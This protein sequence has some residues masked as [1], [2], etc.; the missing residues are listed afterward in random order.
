MK[1]FW[2]TPHVDRAFTGNADDDE[3]DVLVDFSG[4]LADQLLK[5]EREIEWVSELVRDNVREIVAQRATKRG[6]IMKTPDPLP[7]HRSKN[8]TPLDEVVDIIK[9]PTFD[10][11]SA[12]R[13]TEA[14]AVKIPENIS[15]LIREYISI[16]SAAYRKNP[17]HN[18]EHACHVTMCARFVFS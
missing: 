1:T 13:V 6:K 14:F 15:R 2:L 17:F 8:R 16:I 4:K 10:S 12:D 5:R 18:F 11:K 9:M 3:E 7:N